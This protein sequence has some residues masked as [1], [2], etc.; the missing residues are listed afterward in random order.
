MVQAIEFVHFR[1]GRKVATARVFHSGAY[2]DPHFVRK[3]VYTAAT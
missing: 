1:I 2:G 3:S